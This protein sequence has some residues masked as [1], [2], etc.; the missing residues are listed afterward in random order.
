MARQH[1][2]RA[3][4]DTTTSSPIHTVASKDGGMTALV[5]V[6]GNK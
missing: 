4:I 6:L 2:K 5:P 1:V 3:F